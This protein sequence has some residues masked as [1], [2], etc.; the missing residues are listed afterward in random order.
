MVVKSKEVRG[1]LELLVNEDKVEQRLTC[2]NE[3]K[4]LLFHNV[5][6]SWPPATTATVLDFIYTAGWHSLSQGND[7]ARNGT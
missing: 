7:L 5:S 1:S 6:P 3:I 2:V 4:M